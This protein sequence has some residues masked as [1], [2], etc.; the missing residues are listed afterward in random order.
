MNDTATDRPSIA[1]TT[2]FLA[3]AA[4]V[5]AL[6]ARLLGYV[7]KDVASDHGRPRVSI[8]RMEEGQQPDNLEPA[9]LLEL[10]RASVGEEVA[11]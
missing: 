1:L 7:V 5:I 6:A 11:V 9:A 10:I 4:A 2:P 8:A 3:L